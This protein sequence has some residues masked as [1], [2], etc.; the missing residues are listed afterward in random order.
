MNAIQENDVLIGD[1]ELEGAAPDM[2][3]IG[4]LLMIW[5]DIA[6]K[7]DAVTEGGDDMIERL[8]DVVDNALAG[9]TSVPDSISGVARTIAYADQARGLIDAP[10]LWR[11]FLDDFS[12]AHDKHYR[13]GCRFVVIISR[14]PPERRREVERAARHFAHPRVTYAIEAL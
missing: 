1:F 10:A 13:R 12:T 7:L 14:V 2:P 11:R 9:A 5:R 4:P 6:T 3:I 8:M